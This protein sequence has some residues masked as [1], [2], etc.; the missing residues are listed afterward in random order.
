L[1]WKGKRGVV[2]KMRS[3]WVLCLCLLATHA[4]A[5]TISEEEKEVEAEQGISGGGYDNEPQDPCHDTV[6]GIG[7]ECDLD[8]E[9]QPICMCVRKCP[10]GPAYIEVCSTQNVTFETECHFN[11]QVCLCQNHHAECERKKYR[12]AHLDYF[13]KCQEIPVCEPYQM[14][15]FPRRLRNWLFLVMKQLDSRKDLSPAA[16]N[17]VEQAEDQERPW[18]LPVIWKFCDLDQSRDRFVNTEELMPLTAP[19]KPLEHCSGPFL[20]KCDENDDG[21][22]E[23][24]EWGMCLGLDP[25]DIADRCEELRK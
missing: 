14:E 8:E 6:C 20:E 24:N 9:N 11:R 13:G 10:T 18:V 19:L 16:H 25:D 2:F 7:E 12:N 5:K 15:E 4:I 17:L 3:L 23:L 22:I 21:V 1:I